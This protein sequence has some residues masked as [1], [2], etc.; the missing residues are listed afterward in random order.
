MIVRC[1]SCVVSCAYQLLNRTSPPKLVA[2]FLSNLTGV[3]FIWPSPKIVQMIPYL[4]HMVLKI[5]FQNEHF[6]NLLVQN[7]IV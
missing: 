2:R 3:I 7:H 6:K 4:G 1:P 5:D